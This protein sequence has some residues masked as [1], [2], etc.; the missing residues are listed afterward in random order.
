MTNYEKYDLIITAVAAFFTTTAI[1]WALFK[2]TLL[3]FW[4]RP[5]FKSNF[6]MDFPYITKL[7]A[8][9]GQIYYYHLGV[10][11]VGR[12]T[13]LNCRG[14]VDGIYKYSNGQYE[15]IKNFIAMPL[16]WTREDK[17][18]TFIGPEQEKFLDLGT[19]ETQVIY[20]EGKRP[21]ILGFREYSDTDR[22]YSGKYKIKIIFYS[23]NTKSLP[24]DLYISWSGQGKE[25][26]SEMLKELIISKGP[27]KKRKDFLRV[28]N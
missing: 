15:R 7:P 11:N 13:A 27:K 16:Y 20:L 25:E 12:S 22:L 26:Y 6:F 2:E 8:T 1:I 21:F 4:K 9:T 23:E 3:A 18:A 28:A 19:I 17:A 14:Y 24:V 10:K 5:R